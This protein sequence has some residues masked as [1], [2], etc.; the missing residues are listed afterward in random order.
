MEIWHE[1]PGELLRSHLEHLHELAAESSEKRN[2]VCIM[3]DL[4]LVI[5]LLHIIADV[6][7]GATRQ[8]FMKISFKYIYL[9]V[10]VCLVY[11]FKCKS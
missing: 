3:R 1:A 10:G 5:K 9:E 6:K 11:M 2:N 8:V 4:Q 7:Q